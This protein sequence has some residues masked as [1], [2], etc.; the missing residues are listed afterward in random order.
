M[1]IVSMLLLG[2]WYQ[3]KRTQRWISSVLLAMSQPRPIGGGSPAAND[4][5]ATVRPG[6]TR[7]EFP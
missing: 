1:V 7:A 6:L 3:C 2:V 4:S 5:E